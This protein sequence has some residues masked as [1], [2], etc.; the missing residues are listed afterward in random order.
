MPRKKPEGPN[1][2]SVKAGEVWV[3]CDPRCEGR[4][5]VVLLVREE[6]GYAIVKSS[7]KTKRIKLIRF[8]ERSNGYRR[9]A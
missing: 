4:T 2:F 9:S 3:D 6:H 1:P 7:G 5:F 8:R